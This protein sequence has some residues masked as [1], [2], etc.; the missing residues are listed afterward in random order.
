MVFYPIS[1]MLRIRITIFSGISYDI[2]KSYCILQNLKRGIAPLP[3]LT[4][5][6]PS[7]GCSMPEAQAL[8]REDGLAEESMAELPV[9]AWKQGACGFHV[10]IP[11]KI[12][13]NH[14]FFRLHP[15]LSKDD[16]PVS[17]E[18][19]LLGWHPC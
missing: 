5:H 1:K 12:A 2:S 3:G 14:R 9:V 17:V 7:A 8:Q 18:V 10:S 16:P 4:L 19:A 11:H 13:G 15:L 6:H